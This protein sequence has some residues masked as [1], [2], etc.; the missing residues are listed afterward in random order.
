MIYFLLIYVICTN[1]EHEIV[2][3]LISRTGRIIA[4]LQH[5]QNG[6]INKE[7]IVKC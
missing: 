5:V 4:G 1:S 7:S 6:Q 2:F 3:V